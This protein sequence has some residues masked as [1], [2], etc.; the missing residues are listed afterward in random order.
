MRWSIAATEIR[1]S[2]TSAA[3]AGSMKYR[4]AR[5]SSAA[6]ASFA[7]PRAVR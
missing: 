2:R 1:S 4:I 5:M 6:A 3:S 7:E